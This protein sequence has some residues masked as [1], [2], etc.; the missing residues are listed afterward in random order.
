MQ[1]ELSVGTPCLV[2]ELDFVDAGG[3]ALNHG[4]DLPANQSPIGE[5]CSQGNDIKL[6]NWCC[7]GGCP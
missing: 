7:H 6:A 2:A 3:K 1:G 5:V 4:A